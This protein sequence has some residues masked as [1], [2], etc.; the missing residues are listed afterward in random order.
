[1]FDGSAMENLMRSVEIITRFRE[2]QFEV[3]K[4][5]KAANSEVFS[6]NPVYVK[7]GIATP[8][9]SVIEF[10]VCSCCECWV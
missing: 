4:A 1:M 5:G 7:A 9:V 10:S 2:S 6:V 3:V 8:T